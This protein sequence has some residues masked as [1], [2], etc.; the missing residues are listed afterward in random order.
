M[1]QYSVWERDPTLPSLYRFGLNRT[2]PWPVV[3]R[4][5]NMGPSGYSRGKKTS[6]SKQPLAYGVS[7]GPVIRTWGERVC[8][9]EGEEEREEA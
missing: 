7:D 9:E 8:G 1:L 6:N 2:V 3:M 5:T 4:L